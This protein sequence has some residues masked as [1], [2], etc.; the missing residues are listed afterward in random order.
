VKLWP[1][2]VFLNDGKE[3]GRVVRPDSVDEIRAEIDKLVQ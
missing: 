1:T 3:A 2:L